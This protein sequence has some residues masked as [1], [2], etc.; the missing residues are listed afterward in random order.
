MTRRQERS[1]VSRTS[2]FGLKAF[3]V[4]EMDAIHDATLYLL[5]RVGIAV[6]QEEAAERFQGAGARVERRDDHAR[7]RLP[8]H[9]VAD[10]VAWAPRTLVYWGREPDADYLVEPHRVGFASFGECVNVIDLYS[11][12]HRASV[13]EDCAQVA[14]MVDALDELCIMERVLCPGD[15]SPETQPVHNFQA[16]AANTSKHIF[17]GV[18][19]RRNLEAMVE[20]AGVAAGDAERFRERPFFTANVCPTSPLTLVEG[21]CEAIIGCADLGLGIMVI[22]MSLSGGTSPVTLAGVVAQHCA[23]VLSAIALAQISRKGTPCTFGSCTTIM[24][25]R[26]AISAVGAPEYGIINAGIAQMARYYGLP[27]W[28]GGGLSD[29]KEP[30]P[31]VG[32]EFTINALT[33]ALAGAN[34]VY[35]AGVLESG[36]TFDYAKLLMDCEGIRNIRKVLGG[37]L[38][39]D[40]HLAV[41]VIEEV[42]PGGTFMGHDHTFERMRTQSAPVLFDRQ[43]R[44][45]WLAG[46]NQNVADRAYEVARR[47]LET[48]QP[49]PLPSGAEEAMAK[50]VR[51]HDTLLKTG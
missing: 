39:D 29:A 26:Y 17:L 5:E 49:A 11:R 36:L 1:G 46:G 51:E 37:I 44:Q 7:V 18:G 47:I 16:M 28:V 34:I 3:T 10:V 42:G 35:G 27:S 32:Y 50:M 30:D 12:E 45:G 2:G 6:E 24:D 25:L 43:S 40:E 8:Q 31:Q 33:S 21:C 23:E 38:V 9:L 13:K 4:E 41:E 20:L 15:Q 22:P 14:R 19:S 48:H